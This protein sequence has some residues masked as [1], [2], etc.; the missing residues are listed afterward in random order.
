M[1][2]YWEKSSTKEQTYSSSDW[3]KK[4]D[5]VEI[6]QDGYI[7]IVDRKKD[8]ILVSGFNVFPNE[9]EDWGNLHP[10]VLESAA[11]GVPNEKSGELIKLFVVLN[12]SSITESELL[13]HCRKGLTAYKVPKE[14][15]FTQELPKS[16]IGKILRRELRQ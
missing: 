16:N 10:S 13:S 7:S 9:I 3:F 6:S 1:L 4:G 8:M 15:V 12:E 5:L 2:G 14:I 11:I